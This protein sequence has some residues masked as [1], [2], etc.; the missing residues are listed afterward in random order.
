MLDLVVRYLHAQT[1]PFRLDSCATEEP[2][3][4]VAHRLSPGCLLVEARIVVSDGHPILACVPA[5]MGVSLPALTTEL[6]TLVAEAGRTDLPPPFDRLAPP[7]PPLGGAFGVM[8]VVDASVALSPRIAFRAFSSG[9][10]FELPYDA[11]ERLESP[12][13]CAFATMGEL[14]EHASP[15]RT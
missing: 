13:I 8:T 14:G 4:P 5:D 1:V 11:F 3:P 10:F 9:D 6:G 12:R 7:I 2:L 15:P